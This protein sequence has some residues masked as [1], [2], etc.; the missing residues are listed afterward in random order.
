[1]FVQVTRVP[2]LM[3]SVLGLNAPPLIVMLALPVGLQNGRGVGVG[4]ALG[5]GL[6]LG[7][8]LAF[9]VGLALGEGLGV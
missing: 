8:G 9:G 6:A 7:D 3:F 5:E 4:L 1:M 2:A